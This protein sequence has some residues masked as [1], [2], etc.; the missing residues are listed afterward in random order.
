MNRQQRR[1]AQRAD[2]PGTRQP[3]TPRDAKRFI[4][5]AFVDRISWT[6]ARVL[7]RRVRDEGATPEVLAA[8]DRFLERHPE[9]PGGAAA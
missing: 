8:I 9:P 5:Q 2:P 7:L 1:Q 4:D 3:A 6:A